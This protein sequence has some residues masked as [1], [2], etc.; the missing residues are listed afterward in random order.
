MLSDFLG[1][2]V[3]AAAD[4]NDEKKINKSMYSSTVQ[5]NTV[6]GCVTPPTPIRIGFPQMADEERVRGERSG[7]AI[8]NPEKW[9]QNARF[10]GCSST[11]IRNG[12]LLH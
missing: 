3:E 11:A 2:S 8:N 10:V 7:R 4:I 6:C 5:C 9:L 12:A 1:R